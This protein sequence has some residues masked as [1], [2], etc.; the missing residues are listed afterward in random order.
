MYR[1]IY[2]MGMVVL[3]A[4]CLYFHLSWFWVAVVALLLSF[5]LPLWRRSGFYFAL[6]GTLI[7]WGCYAGY[8]HVISDGMLGDR[9]AVTFGVATGWVLVILS[10]L[11]GGLT[12][13]LGGWVGASL[14][15]ALLDG[16]RSRK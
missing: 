7:T 3:T 14:R 2:L 5:L 16:R 13:G 9:L 6:L 10:A 11:W 15:I 4:G 1:F 8:L 12:A